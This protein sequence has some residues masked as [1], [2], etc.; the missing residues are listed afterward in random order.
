MTVHLSSNCT[1][2]LTMPWRH[3]STNTFTNCLGNDQLPHTFVLPTNTLGISSVLTLDLWCFF[4]L[5]REIMF[6]KGKLCWSDFPLKALYLSTRNN[7]YCRS[8]QLPAHQR[9]FRHEGQS[10]EYFLLGGC[11]QINL[12]FHMCWG[13]DI[14]KIFDFISP[15]WRKHRQLKLWLF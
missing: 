14:E 8:S 12:F 13:N 10:L 6:L 2:F 1:C 3:R 9:A 4:F 5:K 11:I 15:A 7:L